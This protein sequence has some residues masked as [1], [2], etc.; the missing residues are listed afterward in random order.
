MVFK[1]FQSS[2]L[3]VRMPVDFESSDVKELSLCVRRHC[4]PKQ[5]AVHAV[6]GGKPRS[7]HGIRFSA[8]VFV[9]GETVAGSL[10][11]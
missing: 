11:R 9:A 8:L 5:G 2:T 3:R 6:P 10:K 7:H 1:A 4:V